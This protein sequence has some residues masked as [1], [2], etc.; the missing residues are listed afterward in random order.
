[1]IQVNTKGGKKKT[2]AINTPSWSLH[3]FE[4]LQIKIKKTP[5]KL[6]TKHMVKKTK[7]EAMRKFKTNGDVMTAECD[8]VFSVYSLCSFRTYNNNTI[9][10]LIP[11]I[12]PLLSATFEL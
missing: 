8:N 10:I 3:L 5:L 9:V 6:T 12:N 2:K 1:M 4:V 11:L 7:I